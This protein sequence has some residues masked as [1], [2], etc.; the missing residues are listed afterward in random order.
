[1]APATVSSTPPTTTAP[2]AG[3]ILDAPS[4]TEI[5]FPAAATPVRT[6]NRSGGSDMI[7]PVSEA[8][9]CR[10][11]SCADARRGIRASVMPAIVGGNTNAPTIMLAERAADLIRQGA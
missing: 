6:A 3:V 2:A 1:M 7:P 9:W 4:R 11:L 10:M 5:A 8:A